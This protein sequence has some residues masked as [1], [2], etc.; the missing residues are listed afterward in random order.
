[1]AKHIGYITCQHFFCIHLI[2][3]IYFLPLHFPFWFSF[4]FSFTIYSH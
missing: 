3:Q 4:L 2:K 1:M